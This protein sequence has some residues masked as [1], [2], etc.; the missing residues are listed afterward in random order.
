MDIVFIVWSSLC[1]CEMRQ[2]K[3]SVATNFV[4]VVL[5][6]SYLLGSRLSTWQLERCR[7]FPLICLGGPLQT[8]WLS[9]RWN[10]CRN[11]AWSPLTSL[12]RRSLLFHLRPIWWDAISFLLLQNNGLSEKPAPGVRSSWWEPS[13]SSSVRHLWFLKKLHPP[14]FVLP[15]SQVLNV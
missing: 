13:P 15:Q 1:K 9:H 2:K 10:Q 7:W 5:S 6:S 3:C 14:S 4:T 8:F 11:E 12:L